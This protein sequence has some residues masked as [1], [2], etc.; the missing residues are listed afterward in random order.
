MVGLPSG[1]SGPFKKLL[2]LHDNGMNIFACIPY[3][4]LRQCAVFT[5]MNVIDS[6]TCSTQSVFIPHFFDYCYS[7][8]CHSFKAYTKAIIIIKSRND[9]NG[10]EWHFPPSEIY[11]PGETRRR[12]ETKKN[13]ESSK[14]D[15]FQTSLHENICAVV[16]WRLQAMFGVRGLGPWVSV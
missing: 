16:V 1:E 4:I 3:Q 12:V 15:P 11:W 14:W 7:I 13:I 10:I 5:T 8:H 6:Q 2:P 9:K